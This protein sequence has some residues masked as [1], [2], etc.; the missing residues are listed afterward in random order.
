MKIQMSPGQ[1]L[2]VSFYIP[3]D[4]MPNGGWRA[5]EDLPLDGEFLIEFS[6]DA[7]RLIIKAEEPDDQGREGPDIRYR[8][9]GSGL[10]ES[11]SVLAGGSGVGAAAWKSGRRAT[12]EKCIRG[13]VRRRRSSKRNDQEEGFAL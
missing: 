5:P 2:R 3:A 1:S 4:Q 6:E 11:Q 12:V 13:Q 7:S 10:H 9:S 8:G